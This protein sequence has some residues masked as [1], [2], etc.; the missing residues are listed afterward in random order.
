MKICLVENSGLAGK[1]SSRISGA[2]LVTDL[3]EKRPVHELYGNVPSKQ[4][5]GRDNQKTPVHTT[6]F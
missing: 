1:V 6:F 2:L 5:L 4:K 3:E